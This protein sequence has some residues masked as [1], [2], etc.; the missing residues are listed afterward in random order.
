MSAHG[1]DPVPP[2]VE[3]TAPAGR[4][5]GTLGLAGGI[6]GLLL[7]LAYDWAQPRILAHQ[8][9][10]LRA[11]VTE[12]LGAPDSIAALYIVDGKLTPDLPEGADS[13]TQER[14]FSGYDA[15]GTRIGYAIVGG[16]AGFQDVITVIFGYDPV[17]RRVLGMRVLDN[18]ETPG[19]GDRIVKDSAFV[20]Q[21]RGVGAPL[22]GV[23]AGSGKGVAG[24]VDLITGAT[25]S[26]R[27]VVSTIN[28]RLEQ[29]APLLERHVD[30]AGQ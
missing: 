30:G 7:V 10:T 5:I 6:A 26:S 25:I 8:A 16:E 19:L 3:G 22:T 12:V 11:A 13:L 1:H 29:V 24:T 27:T 20:R 15:A 4:L 14:V 2:P 21:F 18:K 17:T 28:H 23:K 9:A